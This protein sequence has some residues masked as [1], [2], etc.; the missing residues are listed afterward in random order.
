M[1]KSDSIVNI[2][3]ALAAFQQEVEQPT[4]DASNPHFKSNYVTLDS[5]VDVI[6]KLAGKHGLSYTQMA[7]T[8]ESGAGVIT[9]IMHSSGE[10]LE[11]PPFILPVDRKNAQGVGSSITYAR[12]YSLSAAFGIAS[13][14]DDDGN[15]A[16]ATKQNSQKSSGNGSNFNANTGSSTKPSEQQIKAINAK[17]NALATA[18][19]VDVEQVKGTIKE[20][21]G[22]QSFTDLN[23]GQA[24]E[25]IKLLENWIGQAAQK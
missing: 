12:R 18:R 3:K 9:I 15:A 25:V 6:N 24:S 14:V 13:D 23:K 19:A 16:T 17:C 5:V 22:I 7:T 4:K 2:A 21:F 1:N 8:D 20:R 11:F 10:W